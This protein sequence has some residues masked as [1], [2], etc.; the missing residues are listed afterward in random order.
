[1]SSLVLY[2]LGSS[3][4]YINYLDFAVIYII[5]AIMIIK[6]QP[7]SLLPGS[8]FEGRYGAPDNVYKALGIKR[9]RG[10]DWWREQIRRCKEG[11]SD[12]GYS[13]TG[14]YYFFL[15]FCN[16]P[17]IVNTKTRD[18]DLCAPYYAIEDHE[19]FDSIQEAR[20]KGLG[21]LLVTGR[22][23][24]KTYISVCHIIHMFLFKKNSECIVSASQVKY[25]DN[26]WDK[27]R[28]TLSILPPELR[29]HPEITNNDKQIYYQ[30]RGLNR[31]NRKI[32]KGNLSKIHKIIYSNKSDSSSHSRSTRPHLQLFEEVGS[33]RGLIKCF[34]KAK[35]SYNVGSIRKGLPIL[36][37]TG[38]EMDSGG[39]DDLKEL[40]YNPEQYG[41]LPFKCNDGSTTAR[42]YPCYKKCSGFYEESGKTDESKSKAWH[43]GERELKHG[44]SKVYTQHIA[45]NPYTPEEAF[46]SAAGNMFD[47][48]ILQKRLMKIEMNEDYRSKIKKGNLIR[49]GGNVCFVPNREGPFE[50]LEHPCLL[51]TSPSP[52]DRQKSRMPSSA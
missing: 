49:Q 14:A 3:F 40:F 15:N 4:F 41:L 5:I 29:P 47:T 22:G 7:K 19:I 1:M 31:E 2:E 11:Y 6:H 42:F 45:E 12:G 46:L 39:T 23:L 43:D 52:R 35:G 27:I 13:V 50:F 38:G 16:I 30:Y 21:Y 24:G 48:E 9:Q 8:F 44:N 37:G 20:E 25:V 18:I 17:V 33:W 28:E 32:T 36:I 51:Y 26:V 10:L 34:E